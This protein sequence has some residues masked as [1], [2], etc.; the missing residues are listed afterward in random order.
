LDDPRFTQPSFPKFLAFSGQTTQS[1]HAMIL[2]TQTA[3]VATNS[4]YV[5]LNWENIPEPIRRHLEKTRLHQSM[6]PNPRSKKNNYAISWKYWPPPNGLAIGIHK[7]EYEDD[8]GE[9]RHGADN[10]YLAEK[11]MTPEEWQVIKRSFYSWIQG[12]DVLT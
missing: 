12:Q 6:L 7:G 2:T 3:R 4:G 9:I 1:N 8:D 11:F 5:H 10:S